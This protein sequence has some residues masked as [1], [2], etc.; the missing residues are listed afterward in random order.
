LRDERSTYTQWH[1]G[2]L[3]VVPNMPAQV[4]DYCGET[5][6]HP[7][8]LERLHQLLWASADQQTKDDIIKK[9]HSIHPP[10]G[11]ATTLSSDP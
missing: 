6:F 5:H 7:I 3:I 8:V 9:P 1:E 2:Q 11:K 4:C 10:H